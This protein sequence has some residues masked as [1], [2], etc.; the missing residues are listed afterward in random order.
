MK[1]R[2]LAVAAAFALV[3]PAHAA[4]PSVA[5][6]AYLV[7]SGSSGEIL[8]GYHIHRRLPIASLTKLMTVLIALER[9]KPNQVVTV[10]PGAAAV[11]ESTV[12]LRPGERLT[13]R[14]LVAA[15]L[16]QSAND[17]ADALAASVGRGSIDHFVEL[18][19]RRARRLGLRDTHFVRPDGL[20]AAGH[21]SSADDVT[22]LARV[23]MRR[24]LVRALV[25]RRTAA[26]AGGR[27]LHTWNDLLGSFP[28]LIG[29]KTGHTSA[30]GWSEV[31]AAR[32][33]G[34]TIYATVIGSPSRSQRNQDL[35][36]LLNWGLAQY[37]AAALVRVGRVYA[38]A[39][40]Q[41]GRDAVRLVA[42][43]RLR[44][45]VRVGRPLVERIVAP[46]VVRLPVARGQQLGEIRL[47]EGRRLIGRRSLVAQ[48]SISR[49]GLAGRVGWY[50]GRTAH[51]LWSFFT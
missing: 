34:V 12:H 5:A 26:I 3:A 7:E 9:A 32:G 27:S 17:A 46:A 42:S 50:A 36:A 2:L 38:R 23:A 19:N 39:K 25:R 33:P 8:A 13:V 10:D 20:D 18:M 45:V 31:G 48:E 1:L 40:T 41:Y 22:M 11:G 21:V 43:R 14:D 30:A 37:R 44:R 4:A 35:A 49:P 51:H 15:A 47:Y 16:I 6:R 29:V 24:P 28:K